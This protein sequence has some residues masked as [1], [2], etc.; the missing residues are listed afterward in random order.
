MTEVRQQRFYKRPA[1]GIL[2]VILA[3]SVLLSCASGPEKPGLAQI[4]AIFAGKA[5]LPDGFAAYTERDAAILLHIRL[6]RTA[7][8]VL[9]GAALAAAGAGLQG[10]FRNPLADPGLI[11]VSSGGAMGAVLAIVYLKKTMTEWLGHPLEALTSVCAMA[12]AV[13]VTF[14]IY[15]FS[16]VRGRTHVA[17]MLLVG[18]AVNALS[19]AVV[20][21]LIYLASDD[22]L[23]EFAFWSLGS[24]S[25]ATWRSLGAAAAISLPAMGALL[26]LARPLNAF[27]LGEAEAFHLGVNTQRVKRW[28]VFLS[29]AMVGASVAACGMIGFVG[30][31]VPHL[32]RISLGPDHRTLLPAS[33][34]L[35]GILLTG[36]DL[37]ARPAELP[38]G[39]ITALAGA[40]FFLLLLMRWKRLSLS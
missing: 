40:P 19:G 35:G 38:I 8:A 6:P 31:V 37:L 22:E 15:H 36:A 24:L 30:L 14:L 39:I 9:A 27:L 7:L 33:V 25:G 2:A 10:L 32:L 16:K 21:Y 3:G 11:G 20:G 34:L 29:A 13:A 12:G 26:F 18:I 23:R 17:T 4:L 5:G 28:L 1:L